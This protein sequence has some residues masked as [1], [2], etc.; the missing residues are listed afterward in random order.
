M[1]H[2]VRTLT[3]ND[4]EALS[5]AITSR[6]LRLVAKRAYAELLREMAENNHDDGCCGP[7]QADAKLRACRIGTG[8]LAAAGL[9]HLLAHNQRELDVT[10]CV[11]LTGWSQTDA[12]G[13]PV[14]GARPLGYEF[15][16]A[17]FRYL[18][19]KVPRGSIGSAIFLLDAEGRQLR[20]GADG[21]SVAPV[22]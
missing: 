15:G 14:R 22:L 12:V 5:P 17:G 10:E 9:G 11:L 6:L 19:L 8:Q 21:Y 1:N 13:D 4:F 20:L 2:R 3:A 16:A 7:D 18:R